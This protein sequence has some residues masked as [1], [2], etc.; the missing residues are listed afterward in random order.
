MGDKKNSSFLFGLQRRAN[1]EEEEKREEKKRKRKK[2]KRKKE[3]MYG[4]LDFCMEIMNFVY[5]GLCVFGPW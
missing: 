5:I 4:S 3:Q 1:R 2:K